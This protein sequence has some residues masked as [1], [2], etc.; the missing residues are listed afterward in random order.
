MRLGVRRA[1]PIIVTSVVI[2]GLA[3]TA[4]VAQ[5]AVPGATGPPTKAVSYR[6]YHVAVPA[7]WPVYDLA[8]WPTTCVRVD[9]HAVYLGHPGR[10]QRCPAHLVGRTTALLL[11]PYDAIARRHVSRDAS[12]VQMLST[13]TPGANSQVLV[14]ATYRTDRGAALAVLAAGSPLSR[15]RPAAEPIPTQL[16]PAAPG[17][18]TSATPHTSTTPS[19]LTTHGY[20]FDTCAAPDTATMN[21]WRASPYR[22][23]GIYIGG[24][25]R[26]CDYGNL[27]AAWV[28]TVHSYGYTFIPAYVGLQSPCTFEGGVRMSLDAATASAQG[29][30]NAL[31]AVLD[32]QSLGLGA[33]NPVYV[34]IEHYKGSRACSLAVLNYMSAWT[35]ELHQHGYLA[36]F[37]GSATTD[38][39]D[40]Y[41]SKTF[42]GPDALWIARWNGV[43]STIGDPVVPDSHWPGRR[44]HQYA[45][46]HFVTYRGARLNIDSDFLNGPIGAPGIVAAPGGAK[47]VRNLGGSLAGGPD[48]TSQSAKRLDVAV[49][50]P[51]NHL[52]VKSF[53]GSAWSGFRALS[54][55]ITSD[56]AIVSW[57]PGRLDVFGRG[58]SGDLVHAWSVNGTWFGWDHLGGRII[59]GPSAASQGNRQLDVFV[60]GTNSQLYTDS[61]HDNRWTG[62]HV[63]GG[64][65]RS[66]PAGVSRSAGRLDVVAQGGGGILVRRSLIDGVWSTWEHIPASL[67]GGP[68]IASASA[69]TLDVYARSTSRQLLQIS[70]NSRWGAWRPLTGSPISNPAVASV[71]GRTDVFFQNGTGN[72]SQQWY[73]G[74]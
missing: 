18:R 33:G 71:T 38:L 43:A 16:T 68:G 29:K 8:R 49:R 11:E 20:G 6:G 57:A 28:K 4:A 24:I 45:G 32:M 54:G 23:V 66:D 63:H 3:T 60:R 50:G 44:L 7:S 51:G 65:L 19:T 27:T 46:G 62:F 37:Y 48:V 39:N 53:N 56:P 36:G 72:L 26:A 74:P 21:A 70:W 14:T 35:T 9:V 34:D 1:L 17:G 31:G 69:G 73:A 59:G 58:G 5:P 41:G 55:T 25:N 30:S 64:L 40:N 61:F 22:S 2:A 13:R 47:G 52:Y 12:A 42:I 10:S 67:S 15:A